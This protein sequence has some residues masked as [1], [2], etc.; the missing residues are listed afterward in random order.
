MSEVV[1]FAPR[2][3][4]VEAP[5]FDHV[6]VRLTPNFNVTF[7]AIDMAGDVVVFEFALLA[8]VRACD[9]E[10]LRAVWPSGCSAPAS[11]S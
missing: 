8:P 2:P 9:L 5:P 7:T 4:Q 10:R 3:R 1:A 6:E 11:V